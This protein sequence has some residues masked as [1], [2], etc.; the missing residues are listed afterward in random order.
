MENKM[1]INQAWK[2][3][4]RANIYWWE[5]KS[6]RLY[7]GFTLLCLFKLMECDVYTFG[8]LLVLKSVHCNMCALWDLSDTVYNIFT[9]T[10]VRGRSLMTEFTDLT[11]V[12][13]LHPSLLFTSSPPP[14]PSPSPLPH[15]G[16]TPHLPTVMRYPLNL[17]SSNWAFSSPCLQ[18]SNLTRKAVML[19]WRWFWFLYIAWVWHNYVF[20]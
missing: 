3:R 15:D 9:G 19:A 12:W 1:K 14:P 17:L 11:T 4:Q 20:F 10:E 16:I 5:D 8:Y 2:L 6:Q 7:P 18:L 13:P